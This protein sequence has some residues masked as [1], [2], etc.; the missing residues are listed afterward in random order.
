MQN[1]KTLLSRSIASG[2]WEQTLLTRKHYGAYLSEGIRLCV[3]MKCT[4]NITNK[5]DLALRNANLFRK[6][7]SLRNLFGIDLT[8]SI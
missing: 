2:V 5:I 3:G 7:S 8:K 6:Y 4:E 1:T